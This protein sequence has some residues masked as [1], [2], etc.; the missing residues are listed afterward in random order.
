[1]MTSGENVSVN[2]IDGQGENAVASAGKWV[3][4]GAIVTGASHIRQDMP[5]QDAIYTSPEN[6]LYAIA[7]VAD[8]HG[9][10]SCP[11]SAEG[12]AVAVT[13]AADL[14]ENL[15]MNE[16]SE[17]S[18]TT[19]SAHKDV[20]L[21]K[22]IETVWKDAVRDIHKEKEEDVPEPFPYTYYGTTLLA[23]A[24]TQTF[25][26]AV[27]IG[28]GNI[29]MI[30]RD[31]EAR[32][33]LAVEETVGEDTESLCLNNAWQY[34]RTQIIPWNPAEGAPMFLISTDGYANSFTDSAGFLKAGSDFYRL[35][36]EKGL[37]YITSELPEWL[38]QSSDKGSGDDISLALVVY[39]E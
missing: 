5:C 28:D 17:S 39:Q 7:C 25:V 30:T 14:L 27:Q 29:L 19:L 26:F 9:S 20:W 11:H 31:G 23:F 22:Q 16:A 38:R 34:V 36:R 21:P 1:M 32:R 15:L 18:I 24:A 37:E 8:G 33:V 2:P 6:P 3:S 10:N 12:A 13:L 35:W 4:V